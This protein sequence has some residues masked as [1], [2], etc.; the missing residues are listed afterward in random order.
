ME[1]KKIIELYQSEKNLKPD[2]EPVD[3][4]PDIML[5]QS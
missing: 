2:Q 3:V 1:V 4:D 5:I